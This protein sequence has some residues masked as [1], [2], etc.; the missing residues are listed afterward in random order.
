MKNQSLDFHS[1][2]RSLCSFTPSWAQSIT[3]PDSPESPGGLDAFV[4]TRLFKNPPDPERLDVL[5]A[6]K[7][8][9]AWLE[10]YARRI[11][12]EVSETEVIDLEKIEEERKAIMRLKLR[13][14]FRLLC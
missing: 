13:V 2:F 3:A 4:A 10:A 8:W 1:T 7:E 11:R 6:K 9:A 12:F 5:G 14:V